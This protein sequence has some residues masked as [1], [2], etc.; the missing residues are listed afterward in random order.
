MA[1]RQGEEWV[2]VASR[3]I[4]HF[5]QRGSKCMMMSA[6]AVVTVHVLI[7]HPKDAIQVT[8]LSRVSW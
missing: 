4:E 3:R 6:P 1:G 8:F 5:Q 2:R 7:R